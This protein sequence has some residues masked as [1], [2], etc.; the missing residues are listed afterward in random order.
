ME[1]LFASGARGVD[2]SMYSIAGTVL[3][4]KNLI[5]ILCGF[6][7]IISTIIDFQNTSTCT[8]ISHVLLCMCTCESV[9]RW[10]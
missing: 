10:V 8:S 6:V 9:R 4:S 2:V 5:L 7:L 1:S 3:F